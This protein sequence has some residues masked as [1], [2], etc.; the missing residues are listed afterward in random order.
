MENKSHNCTFNE[1]VRPSFS[2]AKPVV[3]KETVFYCSFPRAS[4]LTL[5]GAGEGRSGRVL[6]VWKEAEKKRKVGAGG[7]GQDFQV[8][9]SRV[10]SIPETSFII[11]H[12]VRNLVMIWTKLIDWN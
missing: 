4:P 9:F 3:D 5:Q 12:V 8:S 7:L 10:K 2:L 6:P 1:Y 11:Q